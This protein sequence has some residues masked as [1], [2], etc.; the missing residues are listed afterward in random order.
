MK[1][2]KRAIEAI[3]KSKNAKRELAYQLDMHPT[4]LWRHIKSNEENGKLTSELAV[5]IISRETNLAFDEI[6][7]GKK[8]VA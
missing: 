6:L 1:I 3:G 4:T 5:G 2:S 7:I 8:Q